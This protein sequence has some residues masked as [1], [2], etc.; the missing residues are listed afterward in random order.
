MLVRTGVKTCKEWNNDNN[1]TVLT[2]NYISVKESNEI[3][4]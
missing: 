4:K 3:S 1:M 2:D